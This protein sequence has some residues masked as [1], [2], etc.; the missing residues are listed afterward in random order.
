[1]IITI[2]RTVYLKTV[3][4]VALISFP[5][6]AG[7]SILSDTFVWV[8][9]RRKMERDGFFRLRLLALIAIPQSV[10]AVNGTIY[11]NTGR[12]D[13]PLKINLISL[14]V[15]AFGFYFGLKINGMIGLIYA[16]IIILHFDDYPNILL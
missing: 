3:Q 5:I 14:P 16:Y 2:I 1:M 15:Y 6:L 12:P 11:L 8:L 13:I 7:V 9:F 10:F 4:S